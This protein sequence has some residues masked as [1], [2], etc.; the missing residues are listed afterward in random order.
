MSSDGCTKIT[1]WAAGALGALAVLG[2]VGCNTAGTIVSGYS[3]GGDTETIN[4]TDDFVQGAHPSLA[5][6]TNDGGQVMQ[7]PILQVISFNSDANAALYEA[8]IAALPHSTYWSATTAEYGVGPATAATP[9]RASLSS[10]TALTDG[11]LRAGESSDI[12]TFLTAQLDVTNPPLGAPSANTL[13]VLFM[14]PGAA[15]SNN[16]NTPTSACTNGV[17]AWHTAMRLLRT[18]ITIPYVVV[19]D[20][21]AQGEFSGIDSRTIAASH[22]IIEAVTDPQMDA[23]AAFDTDHTAWLTP[24]GGSEVGAAC[25]AALNDDPNVF[26]KPQDI[27][28]F[29]QRTWSNAQAAAGHAPCVPAP[30]PSVTPYFDSIPV[31]IQTLTLPLGTN[32]LD[33][34]LTMA[35]VIL[36]RSTSA[37][38]DV[39]LYSDGATSGP[40]SVT[41]SEVGTHQ[42]SLS[43][44]K[45]QGNNGDT[46]SL[47]L[48]A[49]ADATG[50]SLVMLTSALAD[51]RHSQY[52]IV[53]H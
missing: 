34:N 32:L 35:G 2:A 47:T 1:R 53:A 6:I 37:S 20:C 26:I 22:A 15:V 13:Y 39:A 38:I 7:N 40:W 12:E 5:Q 23:W 14:P 21:G 27:G 42:L 11:V 43:T 25:L 10:T 17:L 46:L 33:P 49:Q 36:P 16:A 8:F 31:L 50:Y 48:V 9:V 44:D 24:A 29:V 41:A 3:A 51:E 30:L 45:A 4:S 52:I 28:F 19:P 18:Q